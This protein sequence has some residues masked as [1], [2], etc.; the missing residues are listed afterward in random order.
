MSAQVLTKILRETEKQLEKSKNLRKFSD[1]KAH[2]ITISWIDVRRELKKELG[3]ITKAGKTNFQE[4][5]DL[6]NTGGKELKALNE[7]IDKEAKEIVRACRAGAE[8]DAV[9]LNRGGQRRKYPSYVKIE[10]TP[11]NFVITLFVSKNDIRPVKIWGGKKEIAGTVFSTARGY[12]S[13]RAKEAGVTINAALGRA[14]NKRK[15][16]INLAHAEENSVARQRVDTNKSFLIDKVSKAAL[17]KPKITQADIDILSTFITMEKS[18]DLNKDTI[19]T[20]LGSGSE[21]QREGWDVQKA[22]LE[23]WRDDLRKAILKVNSSKHFAERKGSDSRTTVEKK[24]II[25]T[26]K[27]QLKPH[28]NLKLKFEDSKIKQTKKTPRKTM[29]MMPA[30]SAGTTTGVSGAGAAKAKPLKKTSANSTIGL[31]AILNAKLPEVVKQN[32]GAPGLENRTGRFASGVR[33]LEIT[34]TTQ[35]FPSVGYTYQKNP[36]QIFEKGAG[37][38]PWANTDRDPRVVIDRS[39]REI[40]AG[41]MAG[42]FYTR[43]I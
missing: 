9:F 40:A 41:I 29:K 3:F 2:T 32:M 43:R 26:F 23:K 1:L 19:T 38:A 27:G 7:V 39:I 11:L 30:I 15:P 21:N 4:Y 36:Y 33:V 42:R 37:K 24:K 16:K 10:G 28:K 17:T 22:E 20:T 18:S 5:I 35:G 25:N 31:M 34:Q 8:E 12:Y 14:K 6:K 13:K